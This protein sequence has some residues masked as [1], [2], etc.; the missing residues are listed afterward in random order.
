MTIGCFH[1]APSC[2]ARRRAVTSAP[3]P[4]T[5]GTIMRTGL[6]GNGC[7][8][9]LTAQAIRAADSN[10]AGNERI[11]PPL[12]GSSAPARALQSPRWRS[13]IVAHVDRVVT[14]LE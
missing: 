11:R 10:I 14:H 5:N 4:A 9:T 13:K 12:Q 2:S 1:T 3:P 8:D 6:V 7:A